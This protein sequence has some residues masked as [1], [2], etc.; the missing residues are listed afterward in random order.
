MNWY[1]LAQK[2]SV[3]NAL[4]YAYSTTAIAVEIH[5]ADTLTAHN[6]DLKVDGLISDYPDR[7]RAVL[8]GKAIP[9]PPP[10]TIH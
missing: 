7:L 3:Y 6:V 4:N 10:V 9:L 8:A 5:G 2:D 1:V